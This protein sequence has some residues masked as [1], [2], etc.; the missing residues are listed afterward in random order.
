MSSIKD[1]YGPSFDKAAPYVPVGAAD[2][3][4]GTS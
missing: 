1:V 3:S 4:D 2:Y